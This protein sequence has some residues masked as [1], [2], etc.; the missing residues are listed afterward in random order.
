MFVDFSSKKWDTSTRQNHWSVI[1][2]LNNIMLNVKIWPNKE[3]TSTF[4]R[5]S[6]TLRR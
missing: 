2:W 5:S 6:Q 4:L 1:K 3:K